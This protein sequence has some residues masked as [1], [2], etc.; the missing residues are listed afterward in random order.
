[1]VPDHH[2][3]V[4]KLTHLFLHRLLERVF[5]EPVGLTEADK[6]NGAEKKFLAL[7]LLV[8]RHKNHLGGQITYFFSMPDIIHTCSIAFLPTKENCSSVLEHYLQE[9]TPELEI[10]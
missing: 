2:K 9:T 4:Q 6:R 7:G 10:A 1:M 5:G 3:V 8:E